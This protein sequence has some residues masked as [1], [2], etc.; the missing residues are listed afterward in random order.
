MKKIL[1]LIISFI[2][3]F[4]NCS[5]GKTIKIT[6]DSETPIV[7]IHG[8]LAY[9]GFS[10][11]H[12]AEKFIAYGLDK[13]K[14]HFL[15]LPRIGFNSKEHAWHSLFSFAKYN[16]DNWANCGNSKH[17]TFALKNMIDKITQKKEVN[18]VN[19]IAHSNGTAIIREV[20]MDPKYAQKIKKVFFISGF[21][22]VSGA[23]G[24]NIITS[25]LNDITPNHKLP[26]HVEYFA[27]SSES[28]ANLDA[29]DQYYGAPK[30]KNKNKNPFQNSIRFFPQ[31]IGNNFNIPGLD[32]TMVTTDIKAINK[33]FYLITGIKNPVTKYEKII[34]LSGRIID[35]SKKFL[36][37][38]EKNATVT[39]E[40]YDI[41]TGKVLV[42]VGTKKVNEDGY[43]Y[44][45]TIKPQQY[46]KITVK[47]KNGQNIFFLTK[48]IKNS[49]PILDFSAPKKLEVNNEKGKVK[50]IIVSRYEFFNKSKYKNIPSNE[51]WGKVTVNGFKP[52]YINNDI[53]PENKPFRYVLLHLQNYGFSINNIFNFSEDIIEYQ[54]FKNKDVYIESKL[55]DGKKI[56]VKINTNDR[57]KNINNHLVYLYDS[58]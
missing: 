19:L 24:K 16:K 18:K 26:D 11:Y 20:L 44:F 15:L 8:L 17:N 47:N 33:I 4:A 38:A 51:F 7:F 46:L 30:N 12:M 1:I 55:N 29:T 52:M 37:K 10:F 13:N 6:N 48:K 56:T 2:I 21:A 41:K 27:I 34:S 58:N 3:I 35:K 50:L 5:S 22:D 14:L 32:H 28:D 54:M 23:T 45:E 42:K 39:M 49:N 53:L 9:P 25:Y 40:Y 57:W 43:Y 36:Q 31:N